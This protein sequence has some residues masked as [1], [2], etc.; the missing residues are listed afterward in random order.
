VLRVRSPTVTTSPGARPITDVAGPWHR[1]VEPAHLEKEIEHPAERGTAGGEAREGNRAGIE[2]ELRTI[3]GA[4][5]Q[6]LAVDIV[7]RRE[8]GTWI[9]HGYLQIGNE[10]TGSLRC[11]SRRAAA[12]DGVGRRERDRASGVHA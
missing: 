4:L 11:A 3:D 7:A 8:W 9:S 2:G 5:H 1:P 12:N 10:G 6:E